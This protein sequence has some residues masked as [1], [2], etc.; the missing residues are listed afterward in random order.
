MHEEFSQRVLSSAHKSSSRKSWQLIKKP[1]IANPR[2]AKRYQ[3]L[4]RN[5]ERRHVLRLIKHT[6]GWRQREWNVLAVVASYQVSGLQE[7][8]WITYVDLNEQGLRYRHKFSIQHAHDQPWSLT[9]FYFCD[10]SQ[11]LILWRFYW[12]RC[13]LNKSPHGLKEKFRGIRDS[14]R[15]HMRD[16][17]NKYLE[18][19]TKVFKQKQKMRKKSLLRLISFQMVLNVGD[20]LT[21]NVW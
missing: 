9:R 16:I 19:S 1:K 12:R 17:L 15:H 21:S 5:N 2:A 7:T 6:N 4:N 14:A 3:L 8:R 13:L 11:R 10:T 18:I 20:Q